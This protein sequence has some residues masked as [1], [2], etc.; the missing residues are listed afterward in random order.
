[1]SE[2]DSGDLPARMQ[3]MSAANGPLTPEQ[4]KRIRREVADMF[5]GGGR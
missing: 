1:M 2:L 3:A 5:R 4:A